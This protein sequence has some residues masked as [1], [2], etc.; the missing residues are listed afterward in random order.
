[1]SRK[2]IWT[3]DT[4]AVWSVECVWLDDWLDPILTF[5]CSHKFVRQMRYRAPSPCFYFARTH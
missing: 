3:C 2:F 1:M 4:V 5:Y